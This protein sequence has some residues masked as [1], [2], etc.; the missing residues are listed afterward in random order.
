MLKYFV[1]RYS[2]IRCAPCKTIAPVFEQMAEDNPDVLFVKVDVDDASDITEACNV[3]T[4][5]TF[6]FYKSGEKVGEFSGANKSELEEFLA[7]YK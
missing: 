1:I 5:P 7:K 3:T 6:Q 4:M 2:L